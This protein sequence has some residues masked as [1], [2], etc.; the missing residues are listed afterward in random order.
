MAEWVAV[1]Q[2]DSGLWPCFFDEPDTPPDTSGCAGIAA[3]V[4][5]G[6]REAILSA[7]HLPTARRTYTALVDGYLDADGWLR[8]ASPSNKAE[9]MA[10]DLQRSTC[11]IV[12]P[13]GM[14]LFAQ[15][16]AALTV[17]PT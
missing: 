14:G 8:G 5:I 13:W 10:A 16:A 17:S 11:R 7:D 4:A 1:R 2:Q 9:A 6:V 12:A 15:L 3:A